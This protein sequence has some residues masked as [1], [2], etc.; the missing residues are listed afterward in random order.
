MAVALEDVEVRVRDRLTNVELTEGQMFRY[1]T[2]AVAF[3]SRFNPFERDSTLTTVASQ[4]DYP[5]PSDFLFMRDVEWYPSGKLFTVQSDVAYETLLYEP[6][7]LHHPS[8]RVI[9]SI[10]RQDFVDRLKGKWE[11]VGRNVR[12]WPAPASSGA[13]IKYFYGA[14]HPLNESEDGYDEIPPEDLSIVVSLTLAE[15]LEAAL[16][17]VSMEF[18]YAEGLQRVTK[19]FVPGNLRGTIQSLRDSVR[20]KYPP[21]LGAIS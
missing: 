20:G 6:A 1:M 12:L 5:L 13:S 3:Y 14:L 7:R 19:H 10:D 21:V 8:D 16:V 17:D 11:I 4:Q 15:V 2:D 9:D 18:D